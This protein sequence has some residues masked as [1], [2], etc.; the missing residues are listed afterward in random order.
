[1]APICGPA[2]PLRACATS[3]A[4]RALTTS[5]CCGCWSHRASRASCWSPAS[6]SSTALPASPRGRSSCCSTR[7]AIGAR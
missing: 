5:A 2:V 4:S 7:A 6:S 3:M 1:M